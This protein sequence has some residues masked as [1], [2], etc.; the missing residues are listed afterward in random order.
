MVQS[1]TLI[2]M[3]A[4]H[5]LI[6]IICATL[7]TCCNSEIFINDFI[8]EVPDTCFVENKIPYKL[9]FDS[10]NWDIL[11]VYSMSALNFDIYDLNG[12]LKK[13]YL[14]LENGETAILSYESTYIALRIEKKDSKTME[15]ICTKNL[16][17]SPVN[18]KIEVGN[19]Y[20]RKIIGV[21]I[22]PTNKLII[23]KV[24]YDFENDFYYS[25][26]VIE[27]VDGINA[28][29]ADSKEALTFSFY[30]YRNSQRRIEFYPDDY[31]VFF[32]MDKYLGNQLAEIIIPDIENGKPVMRNTKVIFG[33]REQSFWTGR[34]DRNHIIQTTVQGGETKRIEIYNRI[35]EFNV[36]YK[37]HASNPDTG[38]KCIFTGRLNSKDP[39]G[40]LMI[41][42]NLDNK[43]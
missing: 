14:P 41:F 26:D 29:L 34:V 43:E 32:N 38:E 8:K 10:D 16:N 19:K 11:N 28:N 40:C 1:N 20:T 30:P 21:S 6:S 9:K 3:R 36:N 15:I 17:N 7:F 35:E 12:N 18:I 4:I 23:D 22:K 31:N 33:L 39:F 2:T 37:V 25:N 24:E 27:Q 42:P 13:N 5:I